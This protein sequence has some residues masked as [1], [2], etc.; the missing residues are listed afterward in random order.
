MD[1]S[2][3]P[4]IAGSDASSVSPNCRVCLINF[5]LVAECEILCKRNYHRKTFSNG[6]GVLQSQS[7]P[8]P[9]P[10]RCELHTCFSGVF[11]PCLSGPVQLTLVGVGYFPSSRSV[12]L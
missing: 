11:S 7:F 6:V 9:V 1:N 4:A 12:R 10:L 8:E 5:F 2:K 3:I